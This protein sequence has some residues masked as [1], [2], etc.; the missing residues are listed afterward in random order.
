MSDLV[1]KSPK[2]ARKGETTKG[3]HVKKNLEG[4]GQYLEPP[5]LQIKETN[6]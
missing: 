4:F 6:V 2:N 5:K 1:D 3:K